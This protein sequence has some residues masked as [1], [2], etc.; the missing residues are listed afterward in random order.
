MQEQF[1]LDTNA[2]FNFMKYAVFWKDKQETAVHEEEIERIKAGKCYISM[3]T[4]MEIISV[5]GKYARG[6]SASK[7]KCNC[8]ISEDGTVCDHYRYISARKPMKSRLTASWIRLVDE[9]ISGVSP[10]ISISVLPLS[11][12]VLNEAQSVV[13]YALIHN[14]GSLDAVIAA[15]LLS[16]RTSK[17]FMNMQMITS[18]KGLKACLDKCKL[19]YWDAFSKKTI[20]SAV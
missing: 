12:D 3:I 17:E 5:I 9:T 7:E 16:A 10:V 14:F 20:A 19:P 18:D 6:T 13:Q 2:Y 1:L 11:T 15:T 8:L 4:R